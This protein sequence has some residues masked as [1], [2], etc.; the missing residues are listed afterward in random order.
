MKFK[1]LGSKSKKLFINN[2]KVKKKEIHSDLKQYTNQ[3]KQSLLHN[4]SNEKF[5]LSKQIKSNI[6][7]Y[8]KLNNF[9]LNKTQNKTVLTQLVYAQLKNQQKISANAEFRQKKED[10]YFSNFIMSLAQTNIKNKFNLY[11]YKI[12]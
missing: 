9:V 1:Y 7:F 4:I 11:K 8:N 6:L 2:K 12:T 3:N 5:S 10:F